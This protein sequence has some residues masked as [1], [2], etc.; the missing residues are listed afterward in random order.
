MKFLLSFFLIFVV[1]ALIFFAFFNNRQSKPFVKINGR[2]FSVDVA[3]NESQKEKGLS[4][5]NKLPVEKGM[6]FSFNDYGS[7]PFWMKGMKFSIDIIYI[8]NNKIVDIFQNLP[9]PKNE[10]E[11]PVIV[12]SSANSNYVFEINAG[13]S[14]KYN[15]KKGD[16][17]EINL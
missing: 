15:F 11:V 10:F 8:Q 1:L 16:T 6:I 17:V 3:K 7:H 12:R 4:I 13:L 9:F 2:T 5:Y 14:K